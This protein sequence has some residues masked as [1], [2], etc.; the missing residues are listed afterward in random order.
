[1]NMRKA[2]LK[3]MDDFE[4]GKEFTARGFKLLFDMVYG[5]NSM[6]IDTVMRRVRQFYW[7]LETFGFRAYEEA[8]NRNTKQ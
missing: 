7:M 5:E 4:T 1:M 8:R 2:V 6:Y 3:V